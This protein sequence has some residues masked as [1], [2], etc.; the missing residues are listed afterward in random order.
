MR[1]G[2]LTAS[3]DAADNKNSCECGGESRLLRL[4]QKEP[5]HRDYPNP[6]VRFM[7]MS[8]R[9]YGEQPIFNARTWTDPV[10]R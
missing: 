1:D 7:L 4:R 6:G 2:D 10:A 9:P 8:G 3:R 5:P